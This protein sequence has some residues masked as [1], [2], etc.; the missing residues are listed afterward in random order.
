MKSIAS[1]N[2]VVFSCLIVREGFATKNESL[3]D[4]RNSFLL[5]DAFF[6]ALDGITAINI[7]VNG[8]TSESLDLNLHGREGGGGGEMSPGDLPTLSFG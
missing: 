1:S 3:L 2:F 7:D 4:G 5:L 8:S 6:D